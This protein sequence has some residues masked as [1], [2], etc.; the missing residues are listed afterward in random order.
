MDRD[1]TRHDRQLARIS[2]CDHV[3]AY[4][5]GNGTIRG[6]EPLGVPWR[7]EPLHA[8]LPL[9][10]GLMGVFRTVVEIAVLPMLDTG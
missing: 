2:R 4:V 5:L 3:N 8:P 7:L 6:Q 1:V 10:G 9:T